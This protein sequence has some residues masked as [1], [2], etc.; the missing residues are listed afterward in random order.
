MANQEVIQRVVQVARSKNTGQLF[1][2]LTKKN[3]DRAFVNLVK[4]HKGFKPVLDEKAKKYA[5]TFTSFKEDE[6]KHSITLFDVQDFV[7]VE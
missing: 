1:L 7:K 6:E 2:Y 5:V 4:D 3:G